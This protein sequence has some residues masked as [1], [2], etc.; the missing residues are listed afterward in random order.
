MTGV[1]GGGDPFDIAKGL[2]EIMDRLSHG[3]PEA[4]MRKAS[5]ALRQQTERNAGVRRSADE[6]PGPLPVIHGRM[7]T[8]GLHYVRTMDVVACL[9]QVKDPRLAAQ[10]EPLLKKLRAKL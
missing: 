7:H 5:E 2:E 9:E 4:A 8:N 3:D 10:L 6:P 1:F